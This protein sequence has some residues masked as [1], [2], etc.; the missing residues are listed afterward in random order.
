MENASAN[1]DDF[2][3]SLG[4]I[5]GVSEIRARV[6]DGL[7]GCPV[8]VAENALVFFAWDGAAGQSE[9]QDGKGQ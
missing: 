6:N 9:G 2:I 3:A 7:L 5:M 8:L 1:T 4:S